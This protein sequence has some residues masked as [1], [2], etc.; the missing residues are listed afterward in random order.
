MAALVLQETSQCFLKT[1]LEDRDR[2]PLWGKEQ[3]CLLSNITKRMLPQG[4]SLRGPTDHYKRFSSLSSG[5]SLVMQ[6]TT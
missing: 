4:Q 5:S 1:A 2:V 3:V 6:P